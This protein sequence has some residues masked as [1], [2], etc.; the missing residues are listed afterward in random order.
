MIKIK[1]GLDLPIGGAPDM[2]VED[3]PPVS[4]VALVGN[5][6]QEMKPTLMVA[7]GDRVALGQ[8]VFN[9]KKNPDVVYCA[10]AAGKV[11]AINRGERRLFLS[12][13]I[14]IA[15]DDEKTF[16]FTPADQLEELAAKDVQQRLITAGL[17]P[18]FR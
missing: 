14:E 9:D 16:R 15:G 11:I 3:G 17:W 13:V 2:H 1:K 18:A 6:Y 5:D 12:L 7:E 4:R 10:P 8:P